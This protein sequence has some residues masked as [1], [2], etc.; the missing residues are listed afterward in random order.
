MLM[1]SDDGVWDCFIYQILSKVG[2]LGFGSRQIV[3]WPCFFFETCS[4]TLQCLLHYQK[5]RQGSIQL[6]SLRR[7]DAGVLNFSHFRSI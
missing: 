3:F 2:M 1:V 7:L 4:Y 6:V 5:F